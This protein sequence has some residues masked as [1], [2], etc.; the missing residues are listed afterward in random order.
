MRWRHV[1]VVFVA[2]LAISA[3]PVAA[4]NASAIASQHTTFGTADGEAAPTTLQNMA[5]Q[6]SGES[7]SIVSS[8]T[9]PVDQFDDGDISE[10]HHDLST[11]EAQTSVVK[12]GSHA[13][14]MDASA[15]GRN[16]IATSSPETLPQAGDDFSVWIR[17]SSGN[18]DPRVIWGYQNGTYRPAGYVGIVNLDLNAITLARRDTDGSYEKISN[19][20]TSEL[21]AD[22]WY[23]MDVS[24]GANGEITATLKDSS[25]AEL[26]STSG[27]DTTFSSGGIAFQGH[28]G[29]STETSVY[30][31]DFSITGELQGGATY[32]GAVHDA[33]RVQSGWT[34]LS[35]QNASATLIWQADPDGDGVWSN[36]SSTTVSSTSNVT[37]DLSGT[38]SDRWRVRI[39]FEATGARASAELHDEGLL[40]EPS[41]PSLSDPDPAGEI[42]DYDGDISINVSDRDL[43]LAQGDTVVVEAVDGDGNQIGQQSVSNNGTVSFSHDAVAGSNTIEWTVTDSYGNSDTL[44]QTFSTPEKLYIR[45]ES[46]PDALVNGSNVSIEVR[47]YAEDSIYTRTT[48]D[49]VVSLAGLP[50]DARFA[51]VV[52][53]DGYY[54]RRAIVDSLFEQ[55]SV[56]L[57]NDSKSAVEKQFVLNDVSGTF[58]AQSTRIYIQRSISNS[59]DYRTV[60]ADYFGATSAFSTFLQTDQR[61]RIIIENDQGDRRTLGSYT[62]VSAS[63]ER[64]KIEGVGL[65]EESQDGYIANS[66]TR[67]LDS[68]QRQV[69]V[70][71]HDPAAATSRY[72]VRVHERGDPSN[73]TFEE[74]VRDG[75]IQNYSA[76]VDVA[77]DTSYVVNWTA[78]RNDQQ[79]SG[80]RP[81]GG[82]DLGIRIPLPEQWLGT[83]G[84]VIIVFVGS[85]A[86]ERYATH[87][88]L[89]VVAFAGVLMYLAVIDLFIPGWWGALLIASGGH[90]AQRRPAS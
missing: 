59:T 86:G 52:S 23:Q 87:L 45:P 47:F 38:E 16:Y 46:D 35:L 50:A 7:A 39:D 20:S 43:G 8:G 60:A 19:A 17:G 6:G 62:P 9:S 30:F 37:A 49:G 73:V 84:L 69:I 34:D 78:T 72:E 2:L 61:Y 4:Q 28:N 55:Q 14:R 26:G 29:G 24:W 42:A 63:V 53:A 66:S 70:R 67:R 85:L 80:A 65:Y 40:F 75:P 51:V 18:E 77:N 79:I 82:G 54:R 64:L 10:Y 33:E 41:S 22:S 5:V 27:T 56:Y 81:V 74:T 76:Y 12:Q 44:T 3:A 32:L 90:L 89:A 31:D 71:Y 13:L 36:V 11:A 68:G 21:S 83:I 58:P 1:C 48:S 15:S 57:L 88:A 25:G